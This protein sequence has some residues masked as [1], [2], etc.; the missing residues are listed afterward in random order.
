MHPTTITSIGIRIATHWDIRA[1]ADVLTTAAVTTA[2]WTSTGL[3]GRARLLH[4]AVLQ[5]T[6]YA[7]RNRTALLAEHAD[8][9][10]GAIIWSHCPPHEADA[11]RASPGSLHDS[12]ACL[13]NRAGTWDQPHW[14]LRGL[15][16]LPGFWRQHVGTALLDAWH[17]ET[18]ADMIARAAVAAPGSGRLF[19]DHGYQLAGAICPAGLEDG[20]VLQ[21]LWRP[22]QLRASVRSR[23]RTADDFLT[24]RRRAVN[25]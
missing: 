21:R 18:G 10:V 16:V 1:L 11:G 24:R 6:R 17:R 4:D 12:P 25:P 5:Q 9:L 13:H 15:G 19:A 23:N 2:Q 3:L 22:A 8:A 14:D 20:P 7:V